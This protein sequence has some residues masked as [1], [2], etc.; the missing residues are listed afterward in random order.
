MFA[1]EVVACVDPLPSWSAVMNH[2]SVRPPL[3]VNFQALTIQT[4]ICCAVEICLHS[5][6]RMPNI[7]LQ[8]FA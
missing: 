2:P 8:Y 3:S 4:R 6:N 1:D 5:L 7:L